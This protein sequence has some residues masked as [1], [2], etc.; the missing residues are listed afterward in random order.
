MI[1][2]SFS[3]L[4]ISRTMT[5]S[6][7]SVHSCSARVQECK[8]QM[9]VAAGYRSIASHIITCTPADLGARHGVGPRDAD[10]C[11]DAGV[12]QLRQPAL[13]RPRRKPYAKVLGSWTP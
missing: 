5:Y 8:L 13:R 2:A 7:P 9:R 12:Q 6:C 11:R 10:H 3:V 4:P 1:D